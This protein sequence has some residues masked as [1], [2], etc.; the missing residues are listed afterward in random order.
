MRNQT[1]KQTRL[2]RGIVHPS[3]II[4][5]LIRKRRKQMKKYEK[6]G[7][8]ILPEFPNQTCV[9]TMRNNQNRTKDTSIAIY[10]SD[11]NFH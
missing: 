8:L 9:F 2:L 11:L 3:F 4:M 6:N 7:N 1:S 5:N 10:L